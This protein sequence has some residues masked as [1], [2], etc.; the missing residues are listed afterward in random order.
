MRRQVVLNSVRLEPGGLRTW[1]RM[2]CTSTDKFS[3]VAAASPR[4]EKLQV[5]S[6]TVLSRRVFDF[7]NNSIVATLGQWPPRRIVI[8]LSDLLEL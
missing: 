4:L 7:D 6:W 8:P 5:A 3:I 2:V 1:L